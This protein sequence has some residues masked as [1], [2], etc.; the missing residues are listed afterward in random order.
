MLEAFLNQDDPSSF[1]RGI[2]HYLNSHA[3]SNAETADLWAALETVTGND[4]ISEMM[5]TWT[6]QMGYPLVH[7]KYEDAN[8]VLKASQKRFLLSNDAN[9]TEDYL[10]WIPIRIKYQMQ[11]AQI[12]MKKARLHLPSIHSFYIF[13]CFLLSCRK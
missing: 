3:Y 12:N 5:D 6:R 7:L 4:E 13:L 1:A 11:E 10:W 2:T 9:A 8:G